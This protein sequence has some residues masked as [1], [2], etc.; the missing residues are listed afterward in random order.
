MLNKLKLGKLLRQ[1]QDLSIGIWNGTVI[2][3]NDPEQLGRIRIAID[4]LTTGIPKDKLPWY[5]G[6]QNFGSNPNSQANI[7]PTGSMVV[8]EFPTD[9][10]YNGLYSYVIIS[11]PPSK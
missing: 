9:D 3:N 1:P 8:V 7:P 4:E 11:K 6:K 2:D 5:A 10:I